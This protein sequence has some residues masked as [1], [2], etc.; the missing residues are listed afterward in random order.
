LA[1][2]AQ[3]S[4]R[5]AI[6]ECWLRLEEDVAAAGL[7]RHVSETSAEFTT[8][9]LGWYAIDPAPIADLAALYREAR[10]SRHEL[11]QGERDR[12]LVALRRVHAMLASP[13]LVRRHAEV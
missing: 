5:N 3:G 10:F 6:V 13:V 11:G 7:P 2:L 1:A 4:P 12:A 9:V 8:R